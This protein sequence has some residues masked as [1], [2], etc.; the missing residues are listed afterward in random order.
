M[1]TAW[2][3]IDDEVKNQLFTQAHG[4]PL[5]AALQSAENLATLGENTVLPQERAG[6]TNVAG[7]AVLGS[8]A[9]EWLH[10]LGSNLG[11]AG[12]LTLAAP[13]ALSKTMENPDT[14]N[15]VARGPVRSLSEAIYSGLPATAQSIMSANQ[16]APQQTSP[17][18]YQPSP[19]P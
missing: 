2:R 14:V 13:W 9:L 19:L 10:A 16:N 7:S 4:G 18:I 8:K 11:Y 5:D 15:L 12:G 3:G 6:L 17:Y 1:A